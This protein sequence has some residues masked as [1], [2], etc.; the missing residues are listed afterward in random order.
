MIFY[1]LYVLLLHHLILCKLQIF[2][3]CHFIQMTKTINQLVLA[4]SSYS[5]AFSKIL[6]PCRHLLLFVLDLVVCEVQNFAFLYLLMFLKDPYIAFSFF[7]RFLLWKNDVSF[8]LLTLCLYCQ[9]LSAERLENFLQRFSY[10][11]LQRI[12]AINKSAFSSSFLPKQL[13]EP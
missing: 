2:V 12:A 1:L 7:Y 9:L 11:K 13:N 10:I 6:K 8:Y 4:Y 3:L 5:Y